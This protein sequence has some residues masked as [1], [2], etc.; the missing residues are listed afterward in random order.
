MIEKLKQVIFDIG[1]EDTTRVSRDTG[2][3]QIEENLL[4]RGALKLYSFVF[5]V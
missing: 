3:K 5:I 4:H 2:F 1:V